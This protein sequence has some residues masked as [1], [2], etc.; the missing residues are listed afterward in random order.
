MGTARASLTVAR[1]PL[2]PTE[3]LQ[4]GTD[5]GGYDEDDYELYDDNDDYWL[6]PEPDL[7]S[8]ATHFQCAN[9]AQCLPRAQKCDG[10]FDCTDGSDES[11]C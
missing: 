7:C 1:A 10:E 9:L 2:G 6:G 5:S 3:D 11:D 4:Y 8:P